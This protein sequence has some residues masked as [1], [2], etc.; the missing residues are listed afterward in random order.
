M[1]ISWKVEIRNTQQLDSLIVIHEIE[2][3]KTLQIYFFS[4]DIFNFSG[5]YLNYNA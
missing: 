5:A 3:Q 4:Q 2:E 1:P